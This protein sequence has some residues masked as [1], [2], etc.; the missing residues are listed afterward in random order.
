MTQVICVASAKAGDSKSTTVFALAA[1]AA[2]H[3]SVLALD[4][5][6]Q[7]SLTVQMKV[8]TTGPTIADVLTGKIGLAEAVYDTPG[9]IMMVAGSREIHLMD[10]SPEMVK[11]ALDAAMDMV[12]TIL[13]DTQPLLATLSD[14]MRFADKI[15]IPSILDSVSMPVTSDTIK[16]ALQE[17]VGDRIAGVLSSNVKRPL[18]RLAKEL[19]KS[20]LE[21]GVGYESVMWQTVQWPT[22]V[23]EGSLAGYPGLQEMA[24]AVYAETMRRSC[25]VEQLQRYVDI[26]DRWLKDREAEGVSTG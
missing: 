8:P 15:V 17:G 6:P 16:L 24:Q 18:T 26:W 1:A 10:Q 25:D 20:L 3:G 21:C 14:P 23:S 12:D 19:Y 2:A 13:I 7:I 11:E 5:D 4:M 9:G 22:A